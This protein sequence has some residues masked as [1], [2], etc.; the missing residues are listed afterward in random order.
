MSIRYLFVE[1]KIADFDMQN[2]ISEK[3]LLNEVLSFTATFEGWVALNSNIS[4]KVELR[5]ISFLKV[6]AVKV[7]HFIKYILWG[8]GVRVEH[9]FFKENK[10][11]NCFSLHEIIF[12][13][14]IFPSS[15]FLT[16]SLKFLI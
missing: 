1:L 6:L 10:C 16:T 8:V 13:K 5:E 7:Q 9:V 12:L 14:I 2:F 4:R 15:M 11:K 3:G